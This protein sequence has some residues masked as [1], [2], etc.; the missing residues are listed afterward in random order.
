MK[1]WQIGRFGLTNL[2]LVERPIPAPG[3]GEALVR[4]GAVSLNYRDKVVAEGTYLPSLALPYVPVSDGAGTV[5]AV[6]EGVTRFAVGDRVIGHYRQV[7]L[8]GPGS[9][10]TMGASLGAPLAGMLSEYVVLPASG[11]VRTP[12]HLTDEEASTL[13]I[14]A[15]TA[16]WALFED[17]GLRPGETVLVQGTG[18]VS[19]FALQLAAAAGAHV[20]VTSGSDGKLARALALG[21]KESVNYRDRPDWE[22]TVLELTGGRGVDHALEVASGSN[23][24]RTV[25]A[26]RVGGHLAL[27]GFLESRETTIDVAALMRKRARL[28][29]VSTGH[30]RAFEEMN[31]A[32]SRL[33][34]RPVIDG[35]F[36]F[37]DPLAAFRRLEEGAFGKVVIRV[38]GA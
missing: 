16:W 20:I 38:G 35:V 8:D 36:P 11:L 7:W 12:V 28:I 21:A 29:A 17:G 31:A 33:G 10:E 6:G 13:P 9:L 2:E 18:G 34:L 27:I 14:A 37:D 26:L 32:I 22:T 3:P 24:A 25:A 5:V 19:L 4:V 23:L 15:L 30:R 1:Q